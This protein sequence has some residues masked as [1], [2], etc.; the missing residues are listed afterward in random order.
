M[1]LFFSEIRI[2]LFSDEVQG[3]LFED[4]AH[5]YEWMMRTYIVN[6]PEIMGRLESLPD[7]IPIPEDGRSRMI[8]ANVKTIKK[9][10]SRDTRVEFGMGIT[11]NG[12]PDHYVQLFE[13]TDPGTGEKQRPDRTEAV[14]TL[15]ALAKPNVEYEELERDMRYL[16]PC[17]YAKNGSPN[18][19]RKS[20]TGRY[21]RKAQRSHRRKEAWSSSDTEDDTEDDEDECGSE[22]DD[23]Y[24]LTDEKEFEDEAGEDGAMDGVASEAAK[25]LAPGL[26]DF[27]A[28]IDMLKE[29]GLKLFRFA[30]QQSTYQQ[31]T[32]PNNY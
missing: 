14:K 19:P 7:R 26:N 9:G 21:A 12:D 18:N 17:D 25:S 16:D 22:L 30:A 23:A 3:L 11:R 28:A 29:A 4:R 31:F 2:E 32:Q 6:E 27:N 1:K 5:H 24:L 10:E 20:R 8:L 13:F 15:D